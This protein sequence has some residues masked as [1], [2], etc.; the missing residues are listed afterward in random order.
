[1]VGYNDD[2]AWNTKID[3]YEFRNKKIVIYSEF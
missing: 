1:M 2:P 3:F